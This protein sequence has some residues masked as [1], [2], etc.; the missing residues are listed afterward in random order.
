MKIAILGGGITGLTAA[1][2]LSRR[3]YEVTLIERESVLGGLAVGFK[4][5]NWSWYLERAYHHLFANDQDII[6]FSKEI[7]FDKIFFKKPV[8]ASLYQ[9]KD[10]FKIFPLDTPVDFLKFPY[11]GFFEKIRAGAVLAFL[12]VSP[13]LPFYGK[14]TSEEF[15]K[16]TMGKNVWNR[17]WQQL[18]RGKFGEYAGIILASFIWARINKR[19]KKL[20]YIK[21]GFQAL[22]DHLIIR[23]GEQDVKI[24]S[25]HEI[26]KIVSVGKGFSVDGKFYDRIVSTLP[27]SIMAKLGK[28]LFPKKYLDRFSRLKYLHAVTVILETKRPLLDRTYWLN[29][30]SEKIPLMILAQHTNFVDK[31]NYGG[32]HI[33]YTGWYV[34]S[35]DPL[36]KMDKT[37]MLKHI[38]PHIKKISG[39][40]PEVINAYLFKGPFAQ[41]LFDSDFVRNMPSFTTPVKNFYIAN[42]DM[43]YPYDRGT[44]YAVKLGKEVSRMIR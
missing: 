35:D 15:L 34:K 23:L 40:K 31:K 17:L 12:K 44:N 41:P 18:F 13:F 4:S 10:G 42:L 6:K 36:I 37:Q 8:T 30:C 20:G 27:T 28:N 26:K 7:G 33:A 38:L 5:D 14:V 21:G 9:D 32:N 25:G 1:Y 29:I 39:K 11:L 3:G 22:I 24:L 16:V 19:T 43:T 2:C